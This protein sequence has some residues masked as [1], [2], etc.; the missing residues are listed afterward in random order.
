[1]LVLLWSSGGLSWSTDL[2]LIVSSIRAL[3][4]LPNRVLGCI[5]QHVG[6]PVEEL[7]KSWDTRF[8]VSSAHDQLIKF[9]DISGLP[10]TKVNEYRKRKKKDERMKSLSKKAHGDNNFFSGLVEETKEEEKEEEEEEE[11]DSDSD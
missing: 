8:L 6:E 10:G 11:E 5:G 3:N 4:L 9:W 7:A 2:I 1:M